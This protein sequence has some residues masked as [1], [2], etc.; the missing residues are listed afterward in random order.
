MSG[1]KYLNS[2]FLYLFYTLSRSTVWRDLRDAVAGNDRDFTT[3]KLS[4]AI[5]ILSVPMVLEMIMESVFAVVDI[6]FVSR[7]GADAV[8]TVGITESLMTLVYAIGLGLSISTTALVS[9]RVGEKENDRAAFTAAQA[10]ITA[11]VIF[12]TYCYTRFTVSHETINSDGS[13]GDPCI[14]ELPVSHDP[15][16]VEW[17]DYVAVYY[18][19]CIPKFR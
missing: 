13:I 8:A 10:I 15:A 11:I 16:G 12:D 4:R 3:I 2:G 1:K 7:L 14:T 6:Y 19:C 17:C 5:L 18:K 9:R